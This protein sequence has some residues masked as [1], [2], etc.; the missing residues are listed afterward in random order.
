MAEHNYSGAEHTYVVDTIST[1]HVITTRYNLP[2]DLRAELSTLSSPLEE[3]PYRYSVFLRTYSRLTENGKREQWVDTVLRVIQGT[4]E[5]YIDHMKRHGLRVD[6]TWVDNKARRMARSLYQMQW[7][8]PGRGLYSMGTDLVREFGNSSLNNCYACTTKNIVLAASWSFSQLMSGGGVGFDCEFGKNIEFESLIKRPNKEDF[9]LYIIPDSREG[10]GSALELLMRAYIPLDGKITNK[11]PIFDYSLIRPYGAPIRKMGGTASGPEPLRILLNRVE[12]FL[13]TF[14]DYHYASTKEEQA[15]VY[16]QLVRRQHESNSY[17]FMEY[18]VDEVVS[19]V[20]QSVFDYDKPYNNTRLVVDIFNAI[21]GCVVSG[22]V[23]RSSLIALSDA[24]DKVFLDLKNLEVNPERCSLYYLSNNTVRFW[25]SEDFDKYLPEIVERIKN[26]GEPGIANM[27]NCQ[28]YGRYTDTKYGSDKATLLN[29]CLIGDTQILTVDGWRRV[30]D[31]VYRQ[32]TAIVNDEE[33]DSNAE[34]FYSTGEKEVWELT[35]DSG[36]SIEATA[37][38]RFNIKH[39]NGYAW[40]E[41]SDIYI[42]DTIEMMNNSSSKVTSI[43]FKGIKE[44][45]DCTIP[46]IQCVIANGFKSHNCGEILLES[47]EP[48]TLST[49]CPYNCRTDMSN[50]KSPI[51]EKLMIESA[52]H[53]TFYA[54]VVTTIRHHWPDSNE[55]IAKNR[56]IGVSYTGV[57]NIYDNYGCRYLISTARQLY[58]HIR[59]TNEKLAS[60]FGIPRS[61]RVT[62]IKPEGTLSIVMGVAAGVHFPICR[63]GKRRVGISNDSPMISILKEAG[64]EIEDSIYNQTMNNVIFPI[65]SFGARNAR[66]VSIFEKFLLAALMQRHFSD[67]SVSFTGDFSAERE[68]DDVERVLAGYLNQVKAISMLPSFETKNPYPQMPFEEIPES[69]Y[70]EIVARTRKVDWS[71]FF[72]IKAEDNSNESVSGCSGESCM[73]EKTT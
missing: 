68:A 4:M 3:D 54:T 66:N 5:C 22:N 61:I 65:T 67:N 25:H 32:F 60:R 10:W 51:D 48:C 29:P 59:K 26:N 47:F 55:V 21:G 14:I 39:D 17:S 16:E 12:I 34:G 63:F 8:P 45:Y 56:R 7:S 57:A 23:R 42:G 31:L 71:S 70:L 62:T 13:D 69:E 27:I 53:A 11:F 58:Y 40:T 49:I 33:H 36:E 73:V 2:E 9:F 20:R 43:V 38:H 6:M 30:E 41:L 44:V 1:E 37:N 15:D 72:E 35:V 52:S 24:G 28:K 19:K 46:G 18:N 50:P 64:Y